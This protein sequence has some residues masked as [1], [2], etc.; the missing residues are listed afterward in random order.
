MR[1]LGALGE[2]TLANWAAD[3]FIAA[4]KVTIDRTGWDY[5][6]EFPW[7]RDDQL[8]NLPR[9]KEPAPISCL[10]QVKG[11]GTGML[12]RQVKL[13]N[14]HRLSTHPL[15][16]FFLILDFGPSSTPQAAYLV[17]VD[18]VCIGTV[19]RR[20]RELDSEAKDITK[21]SL[22]VICREE[23]RLETPN[24][25]SLEKAIQHHIGSSFEKYVQKKIEW[26]RATGYETAWGSFTFSVSTENLQG[27]S[28]AEYLVDLSLGLRES[29]P[30]EHGEVHDIRFGIPSREPLLEFPPGVIEIIQEPGDQVEVTLRLGTSTVRT[31]MEMLL[32]R[33][34][35]NVVDADNLKVL[36]KHRFFEFLVCRSH[37]SINIKVSTIGDGERLSDLYNLARVVLLLGESANLGEG[38]K[39][40]VRS[41]NKTLIQ[42][43]LNVSEPINQGMLELA[44][45]M[46]D[47]W[48]VAK[49]LEISDKTKVAIDD[50]VLQ[51]E[52]FKLFRSLVTADNCQLKV[53]F[54]D[55]PALQFE[56]SRICVPLGTE[57]ILGDYRGTVVVSIWGDVKRMEKEEADSPE[58]AVVTSERK[59]ERIF[60]VRRD[61]EP[62][63]SLN[64]AVGAVADTYPDVPCLILPQYAT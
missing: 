21:H 25:E 23:N 63:M 4:Q 41:D 2:S 28:F 62:S 54:F 22:S 13:S 43:E 20:V 24:G 49:S 64:D 53:G 36:L 16:A 44:A 15:P 29:L 40:N 27:T 57:V 3:R 51:R 7:R 37:M 32:P 61:E 30:I 47:A 6:L 5:L 19:L 14:W 60:A 11:T 17:P 1:D 50:L 38:I 46:R 10:V 52:R 9:D 26:V 58:Y 48:E 56:G 45:I 42:R 55:G 35:G 39:I 34:L 8:R 31:E 18:A 59:M 12:N 33:G